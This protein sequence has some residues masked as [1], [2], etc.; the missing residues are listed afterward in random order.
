MSSTA[1]SFLTLSPA[2]DVS[3]LR[4]L[5]NAFY[6]LIEWIAQDESSDYQ[7]LKQDRELGNDVVK[8]NFKISLNFSQTSARTMKDIVY[9][10]PNNGIPKLFPKSHRIMEYPDQCATQRMMLPPNTPED[11]VTLDEDFDVGHRHFSLMHWLYPATLHP[12]MTEELHQSSVNTMHGK[13]NHGGAHTAWS[14]AWAGT[15]WA[16]LGAGEEAWK[17]LRSILSNYTA[18]NMLTLHPPLQGTDADPSCVTCYAERLCPLKKNTPKELFRIPS[19][20]RG[21]TDACGD[22]VRI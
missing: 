16:R 3:V 13:L 4:E 19:P 11:Q 6:L 7:E 8:M 17:S 18:T 21:F 10:L 20:S 12:R 5:T 14:S 15:L 22:V 1:L 9:Q 2:I